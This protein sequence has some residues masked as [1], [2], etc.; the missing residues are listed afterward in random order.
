MHI[1]DIN[2]AIS[3][4]E[5][6]NLFDT[7]NQMY[8]SLPEGQCDGCTACCRESVPTFFIEYINIMNHLKK[9]KHLFDKLWPKL[10]D[11]YFTELTEKK[12]M[13]IP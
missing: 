12:G 4:A 6:S 13:S 11:F 5:K 1:K 7:L 2:R 10:M 3:F 8:G 9:D